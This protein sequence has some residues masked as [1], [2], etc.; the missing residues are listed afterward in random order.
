MIHRLLQR[1]SLSRIF[2]LLLLAALLALRIA[3]PIPIERLRL[4][5]FDAFQRIQPRDPGQFPVAIID[6]NDASLAEIGQWP[7]P[8]N[9]IASLT[10]K[11][12]QAGA[13]GLAFDMVFAEPD[14]LS[15]N[16]IAEDNPD[17]PESIRAGLKA[18]PSN[19]QLFANTIARWP[20]ILGQTSSR[21]AS[22]Q[23]TGQREI[24]EV[25]HALLGPDPTSTLR[26]FPTL[27]QNLPVLE[28]IS[29]PGRLF[30]GVFVADTGGI[31][32]FNSHEICKKVGIEAIFDK[33]LDEF[34]KADLSNSSG[35]RT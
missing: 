35:Q 21:N 18:L 15:P 13:V 5:A 11:A 30:L 27:I 29:A 16:Y 9:Q 32:T 20:V 19:D 22:P 34:G 14:R 25:P 26:H 3:D 12:M 2:G 33:S 31:E 10:E 1:I 28:D 23:S 7:W 6:V 4:T 17:L 24:D 8:R